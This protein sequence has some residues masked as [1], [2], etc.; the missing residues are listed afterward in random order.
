MS[1]RAPP[2]SRFQHPR[3]HRGLRE[4]GP[5]RSARRAAAR[6]RVAALSDAVA[7]GC[8]ALLCLALVAI[9]WRTWGSV[10]E[11][12]GYDLSAAA[13]TAHGSLPYVDYTY[14]YGPAAPLLL[15]GLFAALGV[16]LGVAEALGVLLAGATVAATYG[17]A[18]QRMAIVPSAL[19]AAVVAPVA[20]SSGGGSPIFNDVLP[21]TF[22][23]PIAA[24]L[25]L[26]CP[27]CADRVRH[28]RTRHPA[29][30]RRRCT[31]AGRRHAA[32]GGARTACG[33]RRLARPAR[34]GGSTSSAR[35][36]RRRRA[37]SARARRH[38]RGLRAV[39]VRHRPARAALDEPLPGRPPAR[40]RQQRDLR[41]GAVHAAQRPR[42]RRVRRA[43]RRARRGL[44]RRR[45]R[46]ALADRLAGRRG[47]RPAR[48]GRAGSSRRRRRERRPAPPHRPRL[49]ADPADRDRRRRRSRPARR[50]GATGPGPLQVR[51]T[52]CSQCSCSPPRSA[53]TRCS[54]PAAT[55]STRSRSRRSCSSGCTSRCRSR[56]GRGSRAR[57][58]SRWPPAPS[59]RSA[60]ATRIAPRTPCRRR[61]ARSARP[62]RR[63][64]RSAR[65]SASSSAT[66][67]PATR[68]SSRRS[69]RRSRCC[70]VVDRRCASSPCCRA[71]CPT[72]Q[73]SERRSR[74]LDAADVRVVVLDRRALKE[75]GNGAFGSTFDRVLHAWVTTRFQRVATVGGS[76]ER[77]LELDIW[78]RHTP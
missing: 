13:R 65:R 64:S 66:R 44:H 35:A 67:G 5:R 39:P 50:S 71:R 6:S 52:C 21:H 27:G 56:R 30:A 58:G 57:P 41:D 78:E 33:N 7:L 53:P 36:A 63:A 48:P 69:C 12:A 59:P 62:R 38:G 55:P 43:L 22:S 68:C 70:P 3:G 4:R 17:L 74:R 8:L 19:A 2:S 46:P 61:T 1:C 31:G 54:R 40:R 9:T 32:R 16:S 72:R 60:P 51:P 34:L 47:R 20:F 14:S 45:P 11:D 25:T 26:G 18:R 37:R 77:P 75:Y 24:L 10:P 28:A 15:G 76:G 42:A 29:A 49:S 23:A 73:P